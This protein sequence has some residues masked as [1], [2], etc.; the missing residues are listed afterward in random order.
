MGLGTGPG[1]A[2]ERDNL[3]RGLTCMS[4]DNDGDGDGELTAGVLLLPCVS[5]GMPMF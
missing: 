3:P 1:R 5:T 4:H 2:I